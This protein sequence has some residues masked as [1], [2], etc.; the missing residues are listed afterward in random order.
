LQTASTGLLFHPVLHLGLEGRDTQM[1]KLQA[2]AGTRSGHQPV[3]LSAGAVLGICR[4]TMG[5]FGSTPPWVM[6][7]APN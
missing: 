1:F 4:L 2:E 6:T 3:P 5:L 7:K